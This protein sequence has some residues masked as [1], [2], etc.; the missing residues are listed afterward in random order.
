M[1]V[2]LE[3]LNRVMPKGQV[4]PLPLLCTVTFGAPVPLHDEAQ[5][6][7]AQDMPRSPKDDYL[8]RARAALLALR[9]QR[10]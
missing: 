3:N 2:W 6:E 10:D 1:P 8:A 7:A 5:P 4:I 9:P